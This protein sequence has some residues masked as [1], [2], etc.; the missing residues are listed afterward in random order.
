MC[1]FLNILLFI[2]GNKLRNLTLST[3]TSKLSQELRYKMLNED[4][5]LKIELDF[6]ARKCSQE[7][8][9]RYR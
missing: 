7:V 2:I 4:K 8:L 1:E 9:S 5:I 6:F 3:A